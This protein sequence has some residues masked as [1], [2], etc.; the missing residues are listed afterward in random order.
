MSVAS[1][2]LW[3]GVMLA[4]LVLNALF[5]AAEYSLVKMRKS[6]VQELVDDGNRAARTVKQLQ[7]NIGVTIAGTQLGITLMSLALGWVGESS[8]HEAV[9]MMLSVIPGLSGLNPPAGLGLVISFVTLSMLHVIIG[10]QVPKSWSLRL[11]ERTALLLAPSLR[12]FCWLTYPLLW[13]MTGLA[14]LVLKVLG[15]PNADE[16]E[17]P[18]HSA[19]EFEILFEESRRAGTLEKHEFDLLR[20]ALELKD[21]TVRQ[22]MV[23]RV[24][25]DTIA[26]NLTLPEVLAVVSKTKHSKLPVFRGTRDNVIGILNTRDL[27][28]WWNANLKSSAAAQAVNDFKVANMLRT[29]YLVPDSMPAS[30]LLEEMRARKLQ[31]AIVIDEFGGTC[32]LVTL[33]DLLEQLVGEIWDEYDTPQPGVEDLGEGH[34]RVSGDLTVFEFNKA[35]GTHLSCASCTT[36]GGAVIETLGRVAEPGDVVEINNVRLAVVEMHHHGISKLEVFLLPP[37]ASDVAAVELPTE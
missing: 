1:V 16:A 18:V 22:V 33:E 37:T 25:M 30:R 26:D 8:I 19:D 5:V 11:S 6:R 31:I 23:P 24:K 34:W 13:L 9:K 15:V 12:I 20:R 10:E 14:A 21:L 27:F 7:E 28:D 35:L 2:L 36:I 4:F 17:V 3:L 32:G 29:V